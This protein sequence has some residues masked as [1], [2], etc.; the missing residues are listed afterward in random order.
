MRNIQRVLW[1]FIVILVLISCSSEI[2]PIAEITATQPRTTPA[3]PTEIPTST[4]PPQTATVVPSESL[5]LALDMGSFPL[6]EYGIYEFGTRMISFDDPSRDNR[7][8][9]IT[10]WYPAVR[11]E[12]STS[13]DPSRDVPANLNGAPYPVILTSNTSGRIFGPH[14][15]SHGFM[16]VGVNGM[17]PSN[18]W[19]EWLIDYPLDLV[20]ALD[21]VAEN[22][23]EG[24]EGMFDTSQ[25]G[26]M[27]YSFGGYNAL[28]LSGAR[29]DPEFYLSQCA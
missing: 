5:S 29:V 2:V 21:Q 3:K 9:S 27:G 19:G 28:A 4:S 13:N 7:H 11:P 15:V 8:I 1:A 24:L 6:A 12:Q 23:Y 25:A 18:W 22:T 16:V 26:V 20:F 10:V 17:K 14:L